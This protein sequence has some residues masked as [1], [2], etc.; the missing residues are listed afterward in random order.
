MEKWVSVSEGKPSKPVILDLT[1]DQINN[2]L[3]IKPPKK[4]LNRI[5]LT[6]KILRSFVETISESDSECENTSEVSSDGD[7]TAHGTRLSSTDESEAE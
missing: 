6:P 1:L 2:L 5:R 4:K 3:I 7:D